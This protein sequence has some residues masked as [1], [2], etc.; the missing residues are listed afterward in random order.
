MYKRPKCKS[1]AALISFVLCVLSWELTAAMFI[2][3]WLF[4]PNWFGPDREWAAFAISIALSN[5]QGLIGRTLIRKHYQFGDSSLRTLTVGQVVA[6]IVM[7]IG[8][9]AFGTWLFCQGP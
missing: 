5:Y 2:G 6:V 9:G 1:T 7:M 3:R 4:G 8:A